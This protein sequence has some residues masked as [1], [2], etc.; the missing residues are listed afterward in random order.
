MSQR[1]LSEV[2]YANALKI[3]RETQ[4][5]QEPGEYLNDVYR[6]VMDTYKS[7]RRYAL[8]HKLIRINLDDKAVQDFIK[9]SMT[10][11][12]AEAEAA[13]KAIS[14]MGGEWHLD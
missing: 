2:W 6:Q 3:Y 14:K 1:S 5:L 9:S 7:L 10:S 4:N 8:S 13:Q 11:G 12:C